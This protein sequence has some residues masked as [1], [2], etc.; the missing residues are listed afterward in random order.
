MRL[1]QGDFKEQK[2]Y[3]HAAEEVARQFEHD[4]AT[5]IHVVDLDG[6]LEGKPA[7]RVSIERIIKEIKVPIEVGGGI[8]SLN[9]VRDYIEMGVRWIILGTKACLDRGFLKEAIVEFKDRIIVGIDARDGKVAVDGWTKLMPDNASDLAIDVEKYGG[10]TIIYTDISKDG[11][12]AGPNLREISQMAQTVS[13][14]VIASGG[15]SSMEDLSALIQLGQKNISGAIIGKA[16][17]EKKIILREA[18]DLCLQK[19]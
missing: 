9:Q 2:V 3:A 5:R 16:I 12:M 7:N 13:I 1:L 6:A 17:Y 14:D 10:K 19:G 8:R 4:G 18:L 15:V 11:A